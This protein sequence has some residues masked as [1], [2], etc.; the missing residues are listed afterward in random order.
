MQAPR[1]VYKY[2]WQNS[3]QQMKAL[4]DTDFAGCRVTRRSTSGGV[5]MRGKHCIKH[6]SATQPTIAISSGEAELG[7]M[8]K[9]A[10]QLIGM[11]SISRELGFEFTLHMATDATAAIGMSRRLG[12]GRIRHLDTSLL[13]IQTKVRSGD[14]DLEKVP[15]KINPADALT[16]HISGPEIV[17]HMAR[18]NIVFEHGRAASAPQLVQDS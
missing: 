7:G 1:L 18:I 12:I 5:L 2:P 16:K 8:C 9:G 17:D 14:I 10:S 11:Q 4:V 13:R 15:G 6:W 3:T